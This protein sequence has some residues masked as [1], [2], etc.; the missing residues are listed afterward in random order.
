[1][2]KKTA[3]KRQRQ[4]TVV[5]SYYVILEKLY[6]IYYSK[7]VA[8]VSFFTEKN[9]FF[10]FFYKYICDGFSFQQRG[11]SK[12]KTWQDFHIT[13]QNVYE[14]RKQISDLMFFPSFL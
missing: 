6:H 11:E 9:F 8:I 7:I 14:P 3:I 10:V 4:S 12:F 2:K 5:L 1:M 13:K